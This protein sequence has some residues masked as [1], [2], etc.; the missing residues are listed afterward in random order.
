LD[1]RTSKRLGGQPGVDMPQLEKA[2]MNA[3]SRDVPSAAGKPLTPKYSIVNIPDSDII[4]KVDCLGISLGQ[5]KGEVLKSIKGIKLLEE[6]QILTVL[7]KNVDENVNKDEGP[8]TLVMSKVSTLCEDL[9]EDEGIP[10]D[11]DDHLEHLEP[12]VKVNKI[13]ARK[14]Y[15]TTNIRKS[16]RRR[17]KK[18]FS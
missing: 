1:L 2:M 14:I 6:E 11:L 7:Q 10:L 3:Q 15:D 8:S 16:T 4:L 13:R 5:S 17:I 9:V 12:V 18:Q